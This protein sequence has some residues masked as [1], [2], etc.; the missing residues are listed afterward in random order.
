L[1]L[2]R[3][4]WEKTNWLH[5]TLQPTPGLHFKPPFLIQAALVDNRL[6]TISLHKLSLL[7]TD[8]QPVTV[9]YYASWRVT[10][11]ITYY[12]KA[13]N[14]PQRVRQHLVQCINAL[15][16][17]SF[18]RNVSKITVFK[19]QAA[20][21]N[22]ITTQANQQLETLGITLLGIGL[23]F[24]DF[25]AKAN[26]TLIQ[27][28]RK[29]RMR[30]ALEQRAIGKANADSIRAN[31]DDQVALQLN[32][33]K[34]E[35]AIICSQGDASAAKIY[36]EAYRKNPKFASFYLKLEAYRKGFLESSPGS[37]F[38]VLNRKNSLLNM[39]LVPEE[40]KFLNS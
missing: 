23:T 33:A 2:P 24:I 36:S 30:A 20:L 13:H 16:Q 10:R 35:A 4:T 22:T 31:A 39:P 9:D 21:L 34:I 6:H 37:N 40:A 19:E 3:I 14:D 32:K 1:L 27:T 5:P 28:L 38:L 8:K 26:A 29:E 25:P 7:T 12:L 18:A 17:N 11:P 15:L